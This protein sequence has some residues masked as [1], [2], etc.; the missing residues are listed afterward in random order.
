M[1]LYFNSAFDILIEYIRNPV[2]TEYL[3]VSDLQNFTQIYLEL[4]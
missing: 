4:I 2:L 3:Y 1:Q